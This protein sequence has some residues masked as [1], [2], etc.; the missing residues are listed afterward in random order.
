MN[1]LSLDRK[2]MT[3]LLSGNGVEIGAGNLPMVF[4]NEVNITYIDKNSQEELHKLFPEVDYPR[5]GKVVIGDSDEPLASES[6]SYNFLV[7]AHVI[8]KEPVHRADRLAGQRLHLLL[9]LI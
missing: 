9:N 2:K 6:N 4:E 1:P 5:L 3:V 7:A 8:E